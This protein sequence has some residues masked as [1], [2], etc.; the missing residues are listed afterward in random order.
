[1]SAREMP[2]Y[3]AGT[4]LIRRESFH[5]V[6]PFSAFIPNRRVSRLVLQGKAKDAQRSYVAGR[7]DEETNSFLQFGNTQEEYANGNTHADY[8][9]VLKAAL[10]RRRKNNGPP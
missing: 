3:H 5:Y 7:C 10:D 8:I 2:G 1:M 4:M 6:G 9:R